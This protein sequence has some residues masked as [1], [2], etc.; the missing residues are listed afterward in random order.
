MSEPI[1][2][3][4]SSKKVTKKKKIGFRPVGKAKP[5]AAKKGGNKSSVKASSLKSPPPGSMPASPGKLRTSR[6]KATP[7]IAEP[8]AD[9]DASTA[10]SPSD[11]P[12]VTEA[13]STTPVDETSSKLPEPSE[14]SSTE[15]TKSIL[16]IPVMQRG[17]PRKRKHAGITIGTSRKLTDTATERSKAAVVVAQKPPTAN[18]EL[19]DETHKPAASSAIELVSSSKSEE[20][21]NQ[22]IEKLK[23][24]DPE[25]KSLSSFCSSFK[26]KKPKN[27]DGDS[28]TVGKKKKTNPNAPEND[29]DFHGNK[30]P[31]QRGVPE[32]QMVDGQIVLQESSLMFPGQR[33]T[34]QEVEAEYEVVEEDA[35]LTIIGANCNSF[36]NRKKPKH[37]TK[38]ETKK[39]YEALMQLGTDFSSME[40]FFQDRNRKQLKRKYTTELKKNPNLIEM[41]LN[42]K[43]QKDV[44]LSIFSVQVGKKDIKAAAKQDKIPI[45]F[46]RNDVETEEDKEAAKKNKRRKRGK[47]EGEEPSPQQQQQGVWEVVQEDAAVVVQEEAPRTAISARFTAEQDA[48]WF[49]DEDAN[50]NDIPGP[51][52]EDFFQSNADENTTPADENLLSEMGGSGPVGA[53][54]LS[55]VPNKKTTPAA[56]RKPKFR[57][58]GRKKKK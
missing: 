51:S 40:A 43:C 10:A 58:S 19:V 49:G 41:A 18:P 48:L 5:K 32:V 22:L 38:E 33:R 26:V 11:M 45:P 34:I 6:T 13:S 57:S 15:H 35:Q 4:V 8:M 31:A 28:E 42:P 44:D 56:K 23:S 24:E 20:Q 36:V 53:E 25:G 1:T 7:S 9:A 16:K 3:L 50:Q 54:S 17:S 46:E 30:E 14:A 39:F 21:D 29:N 2:T 37:W 27:A 55:L 52:M 47:S 12:E